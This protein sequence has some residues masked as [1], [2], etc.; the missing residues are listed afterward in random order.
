MN[1]SWFHVAITFCPYCYGLLSKSRNGNGYQWLYYSS[2]KMGLESSAF[3]APLSFTFSTIE[4]LRYKTGNA[5]KASLTIRLKCIKQEMLSK[6]RLLIALKYKTMLEI[7][8]SCENCENCDKPLPN[9][10]DAAMI[11]SYECTFC[12]DCVEQVLLNVCPNC[13]GGFEKR[14]SRPKGD[15]GRNPPRTAKVFKP[16]VTNKFLAKNKEIPPRER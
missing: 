10:S 14:P 1:W 16:V 12:K 3:I 9:D 4:I 15:L 6:H 8:L 5:F 7:R 2:R 11:C 13:G